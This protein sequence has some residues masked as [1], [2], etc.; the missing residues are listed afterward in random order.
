MG[1][2]GER[3]ESFPEE[4]KLLHLA[5]AYALQSLDH[6]RNTSHLGKIFDSHTE[7]NLL[8]MPVLDK[9][10][11]SEM[12]QACQA[13]HFP[14]WQKLLVSSTVSAPSSSM[15]TKPWI[16]RTVDNAP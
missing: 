13:G 5:S 3:R 6:C 7:E 10:L 14:P 11:N 4:L 15:V 12:G 16:N 8:L 2:L 1:K 9:E